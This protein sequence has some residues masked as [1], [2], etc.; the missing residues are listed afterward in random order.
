M[1]N[2]DQDKLNMNGMVDGLRVL[3]GRNHTYKIYPANKFEKETFIE[4]LL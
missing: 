2:F 4:I 3:L 1:V